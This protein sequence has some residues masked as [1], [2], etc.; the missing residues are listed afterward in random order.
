[1]LS[2]HKPR[3]LT[4]SSILSSACS[5]SSSSLSSDD[6]LILLDFPM[7]NPTHSHY[8]VHYDPQPQ[9]QPTSSYDNPAPG[10]YSIPGSHPHPA[11]FDDQ[12]IAAHTL[13]NTQQPPQP[14]SSQQQ[15]QQF[16]TQSI[17]DGSYHSAGYLSD[18]NY[19]PQHPLQHPSSYDGSASALPPPPTTTS[20]DANGWPYQVPQQQQQPHHQNPHQLSPDPHTQ[21]RTPG[22]DWGGSSEG[23]SPYSFSS[24]LPDLQPM[25]PS[26]PFYQP[27]PLLSYPPPH[28]QGQQ[29]QP[30]DPS[31]ASPYYADIHRPGSQSSLSG[32]VS[33]A[34]FHDPLSPVPMQTFPSAT[35]GGT[36]GAGGGSSNYP[37]PYSDGQIQGS[38]GPTHLNQVSSQLSTLRIEQQQQQQQQQQHGQHASTSTSV[39]PMSVPI[40]AQPATGSYNL[41]PPASPMSP[42]DRPIILILIPIVRTIRSN[43]RLL[44][45]IPIHK[46]NHCKRR[47]V[48]IR[49]PPCLNIHI[50]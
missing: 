28:T 15:Q 46:R 26:H 27:Q 16:D 2:S 25:P 10:A 20:H 36:P 1:M 22:S 34:S 33:P 31:S 23:Q 37:S 41:P 48:P 9:Q 19:Q 50:P 24:S 44:R 6:P 32:S 4:P 45:H 43:L 35:A 12:L 8:D 17:S 42:K 13:F 47:P 38:G 7:Y 39:V 49:I 30:H 40:S 21:F 29:G 18:N 5:T 14:Q 11:H 3:H